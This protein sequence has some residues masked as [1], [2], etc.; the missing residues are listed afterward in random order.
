MKL[1]QRVELLA[2]TDELDR[3]AGDVLDRQRRSAAGVAVELGED[4][5]VE[6]E[7]LVEG[8][9]RVD[10][11]LTGHRI[12]HQ[13]DLMRRGHFGDLG[14]LLHHLLVDR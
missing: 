2:D 1:V 14:H 9:G 4:R 6:F 7:P 3:L 5:P 12:E 11:V 8:L 13:V 10:R